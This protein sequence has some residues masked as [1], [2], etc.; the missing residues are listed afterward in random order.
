MCTFEEAFQSTNVPPGLTGTAWIN[1]DP[2]PRTDI[3]VDCEN[4]Q[5]DEQGPPA[6]ALTSIGEIAEL[7][8]CSVERAIACC[9]QLP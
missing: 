2:T 3:E 9:A 4:W 8:G 6:H 1:A 7:S 5:S